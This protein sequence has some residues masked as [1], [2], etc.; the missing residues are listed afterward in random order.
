M[1]KQIL[2]EK[3]N[4]SF[5]YIENTI[6]RL[7]EEQ[8]TS[9]L[10][11]N[12]RTPK[13]VLAHI[14][15]WNWN[16]IEWIKSIAAGEN[17]M[18]PMEGHQLEERNEVF[19]VLNEKIDQRSKEMSLKE[20]VEDHEKSWRT[21]LKLVESLMQEDLDRI[22]HLDWAASPFPGWT[23]VAWR[24]QHADTHMN[25]IYKRINNE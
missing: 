10:V 3:L 22:I 2:L 18:L 6:S 8:M 9:V 15:A 25:Q 12:N 23:V 1:K 7:T 4:L 17:P 19:A 5:S 16:G 24:I 20:V 11:K 21:L 14:S 13:D